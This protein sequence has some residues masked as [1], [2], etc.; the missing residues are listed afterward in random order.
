MFVTVKVLRKVEKIE[1]TDAPEEEEEESVDMER[2]RVTRVWAVEEEEEEEIEEADE[3][4]RADPIPRNAAE[5][6]VDA[7]T[8]NH[9]TGARG[10]AVAAAP[11]VAA[12]KTTR[13]TRGNIVLWYHKMY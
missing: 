10:V 13:E 4:T 1:A 9:E 8:A 11:R 3:G 2:R 7:G 12:V 6:N 5:L